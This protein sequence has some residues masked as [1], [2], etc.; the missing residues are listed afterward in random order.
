MSVFKNLLWIAGA[1]LLAGAGS[2]GGCLVGGSIGHGMDAQAGT[3]GKGLEGSANEISLAV[4]GFVVGAVA[5]IVA[6]LLAWVLLSP[7]RS[8]GRAR[9]WKI[10]DSLGIL[11]FVVAS[12]LG[13]FA[14]PVWIGARLFSVPTSGAGTGQNIVSGVAVVGGIAGLVFSVALSLEWWKQRRGRMR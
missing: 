9:A 8:V 6:A 3:I 7:P 13:G 5:S 10:L 11:T 1:L 12:T 4:A 14:L 2:F